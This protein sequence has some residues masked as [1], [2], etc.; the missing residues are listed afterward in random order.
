MEA[1]LAAGIAL[2]AQYYWE[3]S[4]ET[5]IISASIMV[6]LSLLTRILLRVFSKHMQE[7]TKP[8]E[9]QKKI[10][11]NIHSDKYLKELEAEQ[12]ILVLVFLVSLVYINIP[13]LFIFLGLWGISILLE[14]LFYFTQ[15]YYQDLQIIFDKGFKDDTGT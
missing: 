12:L 10:F 9:F 11:A 7:E 4:L 15:M 1:I 3:I 14:Y 2:L 13:G 5:S 8:T 6:V